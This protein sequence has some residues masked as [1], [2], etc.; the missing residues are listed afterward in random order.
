[1]MDIDDLDTARDLKRDI[2]KIESLLSGL[3]AASAE[4][5]SPPEVFLAATNSA[6]PR[7]VNLIDEYKIDPKLILATLFEFVYAKHDELRGRAEQI[8]V[9]VRKIA[10]N[11][12]L[13]KEQADLVLRQH[14]WNEAIEEFVDRLESVTP[15]NIDGLGGEIRERLK[16]KF[17]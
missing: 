15:Y 3:I 16:E 13:K 7:K 2:D 1:M 12:D 4:N 10:P 11:R 5:G 6:S 9:S 8:G 14:H 17:Q